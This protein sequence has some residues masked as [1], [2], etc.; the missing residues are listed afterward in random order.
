ML[1]SQLKD[2]IRQQ[3]LAV[4]MKNLDKFI[5]IV[6]EMYDNIPEGVPDK[7]KWIKEFMKQIASRTEAHTS[8]F[9]NEMNKAIKEL[10]NAGK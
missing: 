4:I 9:E 1:R 5:D 7:D 2:E 8:D 3:M 10:Q 6:E